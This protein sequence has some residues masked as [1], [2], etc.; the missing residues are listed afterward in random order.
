MKKLDKLVLTS[1][2][3]PFILTFLVVVFILLTQHMLKYFDDIIGK[4][5]GFDVI[6]QLLFY[7][8]IFMTPIAM[9]LAV[10][11]SS[12]ITFGNLGEHFELTAIKSAGISL[13]RAIQPIFYFVIILTGI[14]FYVNN[15]LVPKAALEAYSLLYDIK[16]K[17]PALDLR[18]GTF[19]N[20]IPDISIKVNEKFPDGITLKDVIIY[21]HRKNDGNKDVTIADSGK[22]YTILNERY[23]KFELFN[24][25]NYTEGTSTTSDLVGQKAKYGTETL[26][27]TKFAKSQMVF[28]LSSFQL[29]RTDKKWFQGN[30]IMRNLSELDVDLD[31]LRKEKMN[32]RLIH[33]TNYQTFYT[34]FHSAD[35]ISLPEE[36]SAHKRLRDSLSNIER[37]KTIQQNETEWK[38]SQPETPQVT[39]GTPLTDSSL[40]PKEN[41]V[42]IDSGITEEKNARVSGRL[43]RLDSLRTSIRSDSA[44]LTYEQERKRK[45]QL[46]DS[47]LQAKLDSIFAL[48][49]DRPLYS[50][51]VN[52]AR[53]VKSQLSGSIG[54]MDVYDLENRVFRIQWHKILASSLACVA[55]FLI[56]APLGAIIKKGGLGVPFLVSIL[57]FIIYYLLTMTGEKWAK[58]GFIDPAIGVWAADFILLLVG[59]IFL[60][61]ARV[62]ARLF[63]SDFY[64]VLLDKVRNWLLERGKAKVKLQ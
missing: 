14:A 39:E 6:G 27:R 47:S 35:S 52:K 54:S 25:Y 29:S 8:A 62:D 18:E 49:L 13:L 38:V 20:G 56:G 64:Q 22:M 53:T 43:R 33:Y 23:L 34:F 46:S 45:Q 48:P 57:F 51:A 44:L 26:S 16:Q 58:Q 60:R 63:D 42:A 28:D 36:L 10:L 37:L 61:Q 4:G 55:M 40:S 15:N 2:L 32:Q 24:G 19:Y 11:L 3:G 59:L 9:P 5:L 30:R 50:S 31:S 41:E 21:D 12:L 7:F 1:F 17:K